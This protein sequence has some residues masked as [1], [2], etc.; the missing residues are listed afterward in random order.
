[1]FL[2]PSLEQDL[3]DKACALLHMVQIAPRRSPS[4]GSRCPALQMG[5]L[6]LAIQSQRECSDLLGGK[7]CFGVGM[8]DGPVERT[9]RQRVKVIPGLLAGPK[10]VQDPHQ[11][12][13]RRLRCRM[14]KEVSYHLRHLQETR[15]LDVRV[16]SNDIKWQQVIVPISLTYFRDGGQ[17]MKT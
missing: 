16:M 6:T 14:D 2:P 4:C 11:S 7:R 5:R 13:I 8:T 17:H 15:S 3:G 10:K 12:R 1:M 9:H